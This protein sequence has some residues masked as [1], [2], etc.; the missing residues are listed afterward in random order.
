MLSWVTWEY[1]LIESGA[2]Q[3]RFVMMRIGLDKIP[4][5]PVP[6]VWLL[7]QPREF[8]R[9][10]QTPARRNMTI[11][12]LDEFRRVVERQ[13][14]PPAMLRYAIAAAL[15]GRPADAQRTLAL[16]CRIHPASR[17]DEGRDA[18]QEARSQYPELR[19]V[20]YP[21]KVPYYSVGFRGR[22]AAE[23]SGVSAQPVN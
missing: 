11:V 20:S 14:A 4:D 16:L 5:A 7:D 9:F 2:R 12:E 21:D 6:H 17:C 10:L 18:W 3:L 1:L 8:H 15:N 22:N 23:P 19:V 13:P